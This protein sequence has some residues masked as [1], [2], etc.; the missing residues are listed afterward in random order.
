M[1]A[2]QRQTIK[3]TTTSH[4]E[5]QRGESLT[6]KL[7][8]P[9]PRVAPLAHACG[10]GERPPRGVVSGV[11]GCALI[12]THMYCMSRCEALE[13]AAKRRNAVSDPDSCMRSGIS[14]AP[15]GTRAA[16]VAE[17][18][19]M[20]SSAA[21]VGACKSSYV[22]AAHAVDALA[23]VYIEPVVAVKHVRRRVELNHIQ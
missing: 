19:M 23:A 14:L 8:L 2:Q 3:T 6:E 12:L 13:R 15:E 7:R 5:S 17:V 1:T 10:G 20:C 18:L 22:S 4:R 11:Y 21:G 9:A 16:R